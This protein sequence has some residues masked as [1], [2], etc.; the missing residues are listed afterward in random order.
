MVRALAAR[1]KA[2]GTDHPLVANSLTNLAMMYEVQGGYE[3]A[4]PLLVRAL[5]IRE[6]ALGP[7]HVGVANTLNNLALVY[8]GQGRNEKA[9]PLYA[10]ALAIW[11]KAFG[12][13]HPSVATGLHN[14][15]TTYR[16]LG[17][18]A[19]SEPLY[20]RSL[21][22]R[23]KVLGPDHP[24]VAVSLNNIAIQHLATGELAKA[25]AFQARGN[26]IRER[27]L[28]RNL[29][30]GSERAKLQYLRL[31]AAEQDRTVT[32]GVRAPGDAAAQ[33]AGLEI[34]LRRKGRAL[35]AMADAIER[36]RRAAGPEDRQLLD[37]LAS[38][39]S[40]LATA[41]LRGPGRESVEQYRTN[42]KAL[43]D[44]VD[45]LE[46]RIAR[47]SIRFR[48]ET[49]PVTLDAVQRAVPA[50]AV[51]VEIAVYRPYDPRAGRD[52][53]FGA[54]RYIA[55]LLSARGEPRWVDLGEAAPIDAAVDGLRIALRDPK[56]P[57]ARQLARELD[58]RVMRPVRELLGPARSLLLSPDGALNLVPF[59]A[60]VDENGRYLVE[61]YAIVYLTSGRDLLRLRERT[62][63][64][65]QAM[66]VADPAYGDA[67]DAS[68][69]ARRIGLPKDAA[70]EQSI[71]FAGVSFSP[72][73]FTEAEARALG[74]MLV[75]SQVLT[76]E[77]ATEAALK[78]VAGPR[79]VH[80]ATHGFFLPDLAVGASG[81]RGAGAGGGAERVE[82]PLL[83]SGLAL[84]GANARRSGDDDGVL[85]ALEVAGLDLWGTKLVVLSACDT[86]V[87]EVHTGEGVYGLRRALV[88][89][90]SESQVMSL[91]PV[92]DR[93]TRDLMIT[94]YRGLMRGEGRAEALRRV[95]LRILRNPATRHPF[96]WAGFIQ[97]GAW[98]GL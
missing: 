4:E 52:K 91:W 65:Q 33:R 38:A 14:L 9:E 31:T 62:D 93:G 85:T 81:S 8:R 11:E 94:Y 77:L 80:V 56:R 55:Y 54:P 95:Q 96:F 39:R 84:A 61:R 97:S 30:A 75:G 72:L 44:R 35:D 15:A 37:E 6:K 16:D 86:G 10:R 57:E 5:A 17:M 79:V 34:V 26:D 42:L 53:E 78:R 43:S 46:D 49:A 59:G 20:A 88:L 18:Y 3:R 82:N 12:P 1:E 92:S 70:N 45:A 64:R 22:I 87:G 23:E 58:E 66:V 32:L 51:L 47:R 89:A 67:G 19:K 2:L 63:A 76:R 90:G 48:A 25:V 69:V 68:S 28:S 83:R 41:T 21:A 7:D 71:D 74:R 60:L 98:G 73:R 13:E 24:S 36:L 29:V 40:E 27:E 50:D